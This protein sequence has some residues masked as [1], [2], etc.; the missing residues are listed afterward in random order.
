MTA[1]Q[2]R[3]QIRGLL[4]KGLSRREAAAH[5]GLSYTH[6]KKL[7][8]RGTS[9]ETT[10]RSSREAKRRR[11][12]RC[13]CGAVTRYNG[14]GVSTSCLTCANRRTC[15]QL[16]G[17]GFRERALMAALESGPLRFSEI[18]TRLKISDGHVG[19]LTAR[20]LNHGLIARPSRGLY[21]LS[22]DPEKAQSAC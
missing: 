2:R 10:L 9:Y 5:L 14:S 7:V 18:A 16:K 13:T 6:V 3:E 19:V 15:E 4:A 1:E 8:S 12:G 21:A 11:T 20:M 17:S 22:P